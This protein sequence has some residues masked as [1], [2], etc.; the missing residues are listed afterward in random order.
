[1]NIEYVPQILH[2]NIYMYYRS[3]AFGCK[4]KHLYCICILLQCLL[5]NGADIFTRND[6][7]KTAIHMAAQGGHVK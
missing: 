7:E 1:M 5:D 3:V 4:I 2:C 6:L